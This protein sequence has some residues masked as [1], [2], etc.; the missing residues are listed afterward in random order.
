MNRPKSH[1]Y[2]TDTIDV[3]NKLEGV[4]QYSS[5]QASKRVVEVVV[6]GAVDGS[7]VIVVVIWMMMTIIMRNAIH[8]W[9]FEFVS[10]LLVVIVVM[11]W[12]T[13]VD[14]DSLFYF[15]NGKYP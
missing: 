9:I 13:T 5:K 7:V 4:D 2:V 14:G 12:D 11:K 15:W 10:D 6:G 8:R 3:D 1:S